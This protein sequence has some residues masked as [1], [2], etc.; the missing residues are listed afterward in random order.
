MYIC[1]YEHI[2]QHVFSVFLGIKTCYRKAHVGQEVLSNSFATVN[3]WFVPKIL[4]SSIVLFSKWDD[5]LTGQDAGAGMGFHR[6]LTWPEVRDL[7]AK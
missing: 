3:D 6:P 4:D 2:V 1:I 5:F 7:K